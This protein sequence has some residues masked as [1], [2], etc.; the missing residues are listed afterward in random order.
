MQDILIGII[1]A[2]G[3]GIQG[4]VMQKIG[5]NTANKQMGMVLA[6]F[7]LA[8]LI[9]LF[10]S[11]PVAW[12]RVLI[13]AAL[14]NGVPWAIAQILQIKSFDYMGVSRAM[15]FATGTQLLGVYLVGIF[16]FHEWTTL[17]HYALG[18]PALLLIIAGVWMT[19]YQ[20]K[21]ENE[22]KHL[23]IRLGII[24]LL[25]SA[26]AYVLYATVARFF[27]VSS[28]D[29]LFP[30]SIAM[31]VTTV[32]I[33]F[34]IIPRGSVFDKDV[35]VF[36]IKSWKNLATG[37]CFAIANLTIFISIER[38]GVAVG[39]TL[40]QMNVIVATLGGIIILQE[41]KTRK[42]LI[43]VLTGLALV[44]VGGVLIGMTKSL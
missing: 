41:K 26:A 28:W 30:Q 44:V 1:P 3:W 36:G 15:P 35:G 17:K 34:F 12:S 22:N 29:L 32:I 7:I 5:G 9:M 2:L 11:G 14:I 21:G 13:L 27:Q 25:L 33:S 31:L 4:I 16:F 20:E 40:G 18:V 10:Y 42:E 19:T 8:L 6:T 24:L 23:N 38:N 43:M 37:A 39:W